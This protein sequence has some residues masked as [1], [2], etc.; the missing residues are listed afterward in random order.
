MRSHASQGSQLSR[1]VPRRTYA[2][3]ATSDHIF[4]SGALLTRCLAGR[5]ARPTNACVGAGTASRRNG[6]AVTL[7][8]LLSFQG[9]VVFR[10]WYTL[11]WP[12]AAGRRLGPGRA[13]YAGPCL[14]RGAA[15]VVLRDL[16]AKAC[17]ILFSLHHSICLRIDR[18]KGG[19]VC[20]VHCARTVAAHMRNTLLEQPWFTMVYEFR[21]FSEV[22]DVIHT[23]HL[24]SSDQKRTRRQVDV[25][26]AVI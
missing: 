21:S 8:T 9:V 12:D 26:A 14:R 5:L 3:C 2:L 15:V 1:Q 6:R 16:T 13:I 23:Q 11:V 22:G 18:S 7:L 10:A 20:H 24:H 25:D 4:T 19:E 17:S